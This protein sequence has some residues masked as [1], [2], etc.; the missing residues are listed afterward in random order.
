[1]SCKRVSSSDGCCGK[2]NK[3]PF[4]FPHAE[5]LYLQKD[6]NTCICVREGRSCYCPLIHVCLCM[7]LVMINETEEIEWF[8]LKGTLMMI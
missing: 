8:G 5:I 2:A 7:V 6:T 4:E 1:M 3:K